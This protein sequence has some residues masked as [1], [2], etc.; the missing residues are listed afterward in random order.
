MLCQQ[1]ES[2]RRDLQKSDQMDLERGMCGG[3]KTSDSS[4]HRSTAP[5]LCCADNLQGSVFCILVLHRKVRASWEFEN[6]NEN[7][8]AIANNFKVKSQSISIFQD[9]F[10]ALI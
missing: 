6:K 4:A 7:Y 5:A 1:R 8:F 2:V 3:K 10:L 9:I